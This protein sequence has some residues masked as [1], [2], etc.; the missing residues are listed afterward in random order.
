MK[1]VSALSIIAAVL[2]TVAGVAGA[3]DLSD[4]D[5]EF[6]R[7]AAQGG[8][9]EVELGTLATQH[10]ARPAV[11]DFGARMV[12]D[13]GAANAELATLARAKGVDLHATLDPA[14]QAVRDRLMAQQGAAFDRAYMQEMVTDH[15]QDV[16]EFETASRTA[17]DP[18][19][20]AWAG[21]KLPILREHLALARDVNSQV[22]LVPGPAPAA[23]PVAVVVPWCGGAFI[24]GSGTNFGTCAP[25]VK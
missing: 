1:A 20:R 8:A 3:Q 12:K 21:A 23:L 16:A 18:D 6:M 25:V 14:H 22:V 2:L 5:R 24:P 10:A 9:A 4:A 19:V 17:S 7:K 15:T 13:H 11:K